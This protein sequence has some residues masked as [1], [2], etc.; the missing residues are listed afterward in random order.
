M[1]PSADTYKAIYQDIPS[2]WQRRPG[3]PRQSWL[4]SGYHT[5]RSAATRYWLGQRSWT[6]CRSFTVEGLI[7]SATHHSGA[8]YWWWW[9]AIPQVAPCADMAAMQWNQIGG[10]SFLVSERLLYEYRSWWQLILPS[11]WKLINW[12]NVVVIH[13]FWYPDVPT[14]RT[15]NRHGT[16]DIITARQHSLLCRALY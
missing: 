2:D 4:A 8:C 14:D 11:A 3:R 10:I 9:L 16:V 1:P 12:L 7:R 6:F 5:P 13:Y 15:E